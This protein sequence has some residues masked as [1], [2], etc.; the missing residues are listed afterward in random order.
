MARPDD[1]A[2]AIT[3]TAFEGK[4]GTVPYYEAVWHEP[5][6]DGAA[7]AAKQRIGKAWLDQDGTD[8]RG[9][10][11]WVKRKGRVPEGYFDERRAHVAAPDAIA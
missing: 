3:V 10:P 1:V 9:R 11:V 2:P 6:R 5:R 8:E 4:K 7:R